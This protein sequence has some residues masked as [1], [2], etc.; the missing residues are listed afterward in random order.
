M[1]LVDAG[2][3][4]IAPST[5]KAA[6]LT[7]VRQPRRTIAMPADLRALMVLLPGAHASFHV[8]PSTH[9]SWNNPAGKLAKQPSPSC[10]RK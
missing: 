7:G 1:L 4:G 10:E 2:R 3:P 8:A 5:A 9:S 6:S